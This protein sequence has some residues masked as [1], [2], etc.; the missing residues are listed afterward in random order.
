VANISSFTESLLRVVIVLFP[1][2]LAG[3]EFRHPAKILYD[4]THPIICD[5]DSAEDVYTDEL[6]MALHTAGRIDLRGIITTAGGWTEERFSNAFLAAHGTSAREELVGK[7]WRSGMTGVPWPLPGSMKEVVAPKTGRVEDTVPNRSPGA[8]LIVAEARRATAEKPLVIVVGGSASTVA[9]AFLLDPTI[10][11]RVIVAWN[12]GNNWNGEAKPFLWATE[13]VLRNFNCVL[14][15]LVTETAAPKVDRLSLEKLPDTE[16][17]RF[18]IDKELPHVNLPGGYDYDAAPAI[19]LITSDYALDVRRY[20]WSGRD[21]S[22]LPILKK[23][24]SG[25][26]WR[27]V[28]ASREVATDAWWSTMMNPASWGTT[29]AATRS[30][31]GDK[32]LSVPG[33]IEAER[34]DNGGP[35]VAYLDADRKTSSEGKLREVTTFRVLEHVDF[36]PVADLET[37]LAVARMERGEWLDYTLN[38][39]DSGR[40]RVAA[41]VASIAGG[42][43]RIS[44]DGRDATGRI[45]VPATRGLQ[46]WRTVE[47]GLVELSRGPK[48]MSVNVEEGKFTLDWIEISS[49]GVSP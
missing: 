18:M 1:L 31:F 20:R 12:G 16:L 39:T 48:V 27:V 45:A 7:A 5:N 14:F 41:R 2:L 40:Y 29:P 3:C 13:I 44:F 36:S 15:D 49:D 37:G 4:S 8:D 9:D 24:A 35:G 34:F 30:P 47:L 17:R 32:P 43:M 38:V 23:D 33:R 25:N 6:L 26:L 28:R 19:P 21:K 42:A 46:T 22:G 10:K 11:D